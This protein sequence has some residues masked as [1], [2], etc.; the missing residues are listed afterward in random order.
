MLVFFHSV[1]CVNSSNFTKSVNSISNI[2]AICIRLP[3]FG[4]LELVHHLNIVVWSLHNYSDNHLFVHRFSVKTAFSRFNFLQE[5]KQLVQIKQRAILF[6]LSSYFLFLHQ[7]SISSLIPQ[8]FCLF[9]NFQGKLCL[10]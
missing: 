5:H 7:K 2:L 9:N 6:I 3:K 10:F 4:R 8:F 1:L